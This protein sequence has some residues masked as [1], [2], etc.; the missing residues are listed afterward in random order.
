VPGP[1]VPLYLLGRKI[2]RWYPYVPIGGEMGLN[3]AML[4]YNDTAYFGFTGDAPA[5]PHLH[6]LERFL[7]LSFAELQ[8]AAGIRLRRPRREPPKPSLVSTPKP[9]AKEKEVVLSASA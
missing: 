2:L 4:S 8:K 1:Q 3:C 7:R 5:A 9:A 6:R